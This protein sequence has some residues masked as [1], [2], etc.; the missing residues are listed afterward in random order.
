MLKSILW[1]WGIPEKLSII[2]A[3]FHVRSPREGT[4]SRSRHWTKQ[5][6]LNCGTLDGAFIPSN[7]LLSR[8]HLME[9]PLR[10]CWDREDNVERGVWAFHI[11]GVLSKCVLQKQHLCGLETGPSPWDHTWTAHDMQVRE[12]RRTGPHCLGLTDTVDTE[13]R[14]WEDRS[15]HRLSS[16]VYESWWTT[17]MSIIMG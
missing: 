13:R 7:Q 8:K 14:H 17:E 10:R 6:S 9:P 1:H 11:S 3:H 15:N 4:R 2:T 16:K 12:Q 5:H